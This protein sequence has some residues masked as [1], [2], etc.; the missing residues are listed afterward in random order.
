MRALHYIKK[1]QLEWRDISDATLESD[2]DA[3]IKP[4]AVA[5]CDLDRNIVDGRSPFPGPFV[6]GHEFCG[7]VLHLGEAVNGLKVAD[8][9]LASFQPSCGSCAPCGLGHSSVCSNVSNT[10]MYGIGG[11]GGDWSGALAECIKVP[12]A[13]YNLRKLPGGLEPTA[14]ASASDN[15]ADALRA[16]DAP[17]QKQPGASVLVAGRG[18]IGLYTVLCAKYLG[19]E[20]VTFASQDQ[21][22]LMIAEGLG[23]ECIEICAWPKKLAQHDIT[24]DVTNSRA[25]LSTVIKSTAP[26]GYCT[27]GSIYFAPTTPIPLVDMYMK[28]IEFHTGR[29]NSASVLDRV[30]ELV[31]KGLNPAAI[32][33]MIASFDDA[34]D[35]LLSAPK[36]RK[37]IFTQ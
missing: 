22:E 34:I 12:W 36:A 27:S 11:A 30:L 35:V 1:Q 19:A 3:I 8:V 2:T 21:E 5:A 20:K 37:L 15:L 13:E 23:A 24:M 17:L 6:L 7:E 26:Y 32:E 31:A 9:V 14:L 25:G 4:L 33:P 18:S 16:V 29:V 10:S 28:G